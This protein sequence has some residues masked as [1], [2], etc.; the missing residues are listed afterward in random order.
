MTSI[1]ELAE[2]VE[3]QYVSQS[4]SQAYISGKF[5]VGADGKRGYVRKKYLE[6]KGIKQAPG[7]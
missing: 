3:V 1:E 6:A 7:V 2:G 4:E 5:L